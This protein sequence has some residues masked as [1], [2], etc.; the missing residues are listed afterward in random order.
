MGH[1][2]YIAYRG[3]GGTAAA[4]ITTALQKVDLT[5]VD[6]EPYVLDD[7]DAQGVDWVLAEGPEI[8]P[9]K[10]ARACEEAALDGL[11][12]A[13]VGMLLTAHGDVGRAGSHLLP[14]PYAVTGEELEELDR[15]YVEEHADMLLRCPDWIRVRRLDVTVVAGEP[16]HRIVLHDVARADIFDAPEVQASMATPWRK[17]L[18]SRPWFLAGGRYVLRKVSP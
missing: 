5:D 12:S 6:V 2:A 15:W 9:G 13:G 14:V 18:A 10:W 4:R 8:D 11:V 1:V 16:W 17:D 7:P 3:D